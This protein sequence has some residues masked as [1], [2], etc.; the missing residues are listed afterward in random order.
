MAADCSVLDV[1]RNNALWC[2]AV[3]RA[4]G[5]PGTFQEAL[6]L[7][8]A[9]MPPYYPHAVTLTPGGAA[10]Q[11]ASIAQLAAARATFGVKDSFAALDLRPLGCAVLF[12]ATWLTRPAGAPPPAMTGDH[13]AVVEDAAALAGWEAAWAGLPAEQT[14][15]DAGRV[16]PPLLLAETGVRFLAGWRDGSIFAVA[17]ANATGPVVGLSN[18]YSLVGDTAAC[19]AGAVALAGRLF[20]GRPLVGYERGDDLIAAQRVG[21]RPLGELRVWAR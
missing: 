12:A 2:D 4:H 18:V 5:A 14:I 8:P 6:W 3:G 9:D 16:F 17:V 13:W 11:L 15:P 20:P 1:A 7:H 21:F 19:W 10:E